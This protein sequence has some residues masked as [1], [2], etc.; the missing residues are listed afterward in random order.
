MSIPRLHPDTIEDVKQRID[1]VDIVSDH[2]VLKKQGKDMTGLCPFHDDKSPS[3]TVSPSKQ[4]YYCFSCGAGG[5][6]IK[7]LMELGKVSFGEVVLDLAN[8][9]QVPVQTLEPEQRQELQHKLT[10]REQLYEILAVTTQFYSHALHQPQGAAALTY[11]TDSRRLQPLTL[12]QF[13]L[14][15]APAGWATLYGYLV[16]QKH[17]PVQ[18]V[19]QAGL[20]VPRKSGSGYYDRF[21]DRLMIPICDLQGRTIGFGGRTLSGEDP[22]YL[23]SPETELFSK[24]NTLFGLDKARNTIAKDDRAVVVEGYFD[25]IALHAVGVT[26]AVAALGT[27]LSLNQVKLLLRYTDAKRIILNFDADGA[28]SRA[29]ERAIGEVEALAYQG[30]VELR[31]MNLPGGKDADEYLYQH[32]AGDYQDLLDHAPLWIDWQ[33]QTLI[34]DHDLTQPDQF[35][36]AIQGIVKL[37]GNL[38][39]TPLRTHYIHRCAELLSQGEARVALR[40]EEDLRLQVQGQR[41]HGRSQRWAK[42]GDASVRELAEAQLL[43]IY[44]HCPETRSLLKTVLQQRQ[45]NFTIHTHRILWRSILELEPQDQGDDLLQRL[46]D[47][48]AD[49]PLPAVAENQGHVM[50]IVQPSE[51]QR[52]ELYRPQLG[53]RSA[54]ATLERLE[55]EKRCRHLLSSWQTHRLESMERCMTD[56]L[57]E[58]LDPAQDL[59]LRIEALY[60]SLNHEI[61]DF[62]RRFYD[63]WRYLQALNRHRCTTSEDLAQG[64]YTAPSQP[65]SVV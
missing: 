19:E 39:H 4:F 59:E 49:L 57:Q 17:Y 53:I 25:V 63:E 13:Q 18:L 26:N 51:V 14:G 62:Q 12:Q 28:G 44:L 42:P 38:P 33:I 52:V 9:Y 6:A 31:V 35:Q 2:V 24:G 15:Y 36:P 47:G 65:V 64:T 29:T 55:C 41:W 11:L 30:Q 61:L 46:R 10:L 60:H 56:L 23:N 8:R 5:N 1:I 32:S 16:E 43:R 45:L 50:G 48:L 20:I 40:L 3:F 54:A 7:F 22:K 58:E 21:R 34:A 37:L 27:A